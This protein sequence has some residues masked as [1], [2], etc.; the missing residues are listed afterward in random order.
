MGLIKS[1]SLRGGCSRNS[2]RKKQFERSATRYTGH[3][4]KQKQCQYIWERRGKDY[5][6]WK[7]KANT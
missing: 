5:D 6:Q 7:I 4:S 1:R 2:E 3:H